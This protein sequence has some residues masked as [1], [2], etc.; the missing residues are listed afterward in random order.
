M[1]TDPSQLEWLS[2]VEVSGPFLAAPVLENAFPQ[3][4]EPVVTSTRRRIRAA[5]EEWRDAVDQDDPLLPRLHAEW[6]HLILTELLEFDADSLVAWKSDGLLASVEDGVGG[7]S[8]LAPTWVVRSPS[9]IDSKLL[10]FAVP[11][12]SDLG[13]IG[14]GAGAAELYE[15]VTAFCR[16]STV[17]VGLLTNGEQ[18]MVINAPLGLISGQASWYARYWF[19]EPVTLRAFQAL[20]NV[21]RCFGPA[22]RTLDALLEES[23]KHQDHV[24]DTLGEQV[25]RAVEVLIQALDKADVDRNRDLLRGVSPDEL[26]EA[27]LTVMMRLVFIL[28]AEERGLLLLGDPVYDDSYAASTLRGQL[29]DAADLHGYE[30]L[31]R[32]QDAWS[33]LLA[34]FRGIFGGIAHENIHLP[35]MGSSLF[36]PDRFSFLEGRAP[37]APWMTDISVPVPIDNRTVLLLLNSLQVLERPDG[38]LTLSYRALDVEQIGHIYERLL[39][40][41]VVRA[42]TI[43]LG[44]KGTS[45]RQAPNISLASLESALMAG[46]EQLESVVQQT[47]GRSIAAIRNDLS[48]AHDD[49]A[50]AESVATLIDARLA[51]RIQ[52]FAALLRVDAWGEPVVYGSGSF[53]VTAGTDRQE[54][55]SHYTPRFLT[56]KLVKQA[57]DPM[58]HASSVDAGDPELRTP[59]ALLNLRVCD[60]AM[61]SG[62]FLVQACRYL[63]EHLVLAW[64][65]AERGGA[66]VTIEGEVVQ[67][68]RDRDPLPGHPEERIAIARSLVAERCLYGVDINPLAVEL[69]K[70]SLW[71][72]TLAKAR[73]LGFLDHNLRSGD[74]I[75]GLTSFDQLEQLNTKPDLIKYQP[76][77]FRSVLEE[78]T[79]EAT[80][81]RRRLRCTPV[82]GIDDIKSMA[83]LNA[84]AQE[85]L[86]GM[87]AI[88][89]GLVGEALY[90][91]GDKRGLHMGREALALEAIA[92]AHGDDEARLRVRARAQVALAVGGE[93]Q[94]SRRPFHW[95]LEFPEVLARSERCGFDVVVGNPPWASYSGR[96]AVPLDAWSASYYSSHFRSFGGWKA[97]HS[98]FI[99]QALRITAEGGTLALLVPAQ[100]ADLKGYGPVRAVLRSYAVISEPAPYFGEAAFVGVTQPSC[101]VIASKILSTASDPPASEEAFTLDTLAD[102]GEI[103]VTHD[104]DTGLD[105]VLSKLRILPK[106]RSDAFADP[107][108]HS[109]NSAKKIVLSA[110]PQAGAAA[111]V[112]EGRSVFPHRLEPPTKWLLLDYRPEEGEYFTIR[113]LKLY[114][115]FPILLRQTAKRPIAAKHS[116]R[117][118]FRNSILA[119]RGLSGVPVDAVVAWLNSSAVAVFHMTSVREAN[120]KAFPQVKIRHLRDLPTPRW[121][122]MLDA[123]GSRL[124]ELC[125][126]ASRG[127]TDALDELDSSVSRAC[128]LDQSEHE[129]V[130]R[131]LARLEEG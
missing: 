104:R 26:Y 129:T 100:V 50:A 110:R 91:K 94:H 47:C 4:L 28:C 25:R 66:S 11:P 6:I 18:W 130:R 72:V 65:T 5:Y 128:G 46:Q 123:V 99:E 59:E 21:R 54:T 73:P 10:V 131:A 98:L 126:A 101:A 16:A 74:S 105:A 2:L 57:L 88:A 60:P 76:D 117:T 90:W 52:P 63:A 115:S 22:E 36:D 116:D 7:S 42:E 77:M 29:A 1:M 17:R 19:Q 113:D 40:Y 111:P 62:A 71:L 37:G 51:K 106:V 33:R 39:E 79:S 107:G 15:R 108:V 121:D 80:S 86:R 31:E 64:Q 9:S 97:L 3:G 127:D 122:V 82:R 13:T 119:C 27:G 55:G 43:S 93:P 89:D 12:G 103:A 68:L 58:V 34:L 23:T 24:T 56:E 48:R 49:G 85:I 32:R 30:V 53:V 95:V 109:G 61:G 125:D 44:L 124:A 120:Q 87:D 41:S 84:K 102:Q 118:Y 92:I 35:A 83:L 20:L 8:G 96:Q 69:A 67:A 112:R 38:A 75:L 45:R 81:I 78:L 70:L 114:A 14:Q